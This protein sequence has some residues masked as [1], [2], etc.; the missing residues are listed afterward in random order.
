MKTFGCQVGLFTS[1]LILFFS[2]TA[3]FAAEELPGTAP[4]NATG[5]L[6]AS[7]VDGIHHWLDRATAATPTN[8]AKLWTVAI[9]PKNGAPARDLTWYCHRYDSNRV[10]LR[11]QLGLRDTRLPPALRFVTT[12]N[13]FDPSPT[14][15]E[16]ARGRGYRVFAVEWDVLRDVR[17]EGLLL[18]PD[19]TPRADVIAIPDCE[20][21][22]E[23]IT[24][25]AP[26]LPPEQQFARLLAEHGCRVLVPALIDRS[27]A[28]AGNPDY[29]R[30]QYSQRET[31]WRAAWEMGR[32]PTSYELQKIFA[33]A[34]WL[35]STRPPDRQPPAFDDAAAQSKAGRKG[36]DY[37]ELGVFG[38]GEGG[39]LA[40]LAAA[41]D[42]RFAA[43]YVSGYFGPRERLWEEPIDRDVHG[44]LNEFGDA[45]I[46]ALI[47]PRPLWLES[48][49]YPKAEFTDAHGGAPGRLTSPSSH[50]VTLE[51]ERLQSLVDFPESMLHAEPERF[52]DHTSRFLL[53]LGALNPKVGYLPGPP[54]QGLTPNPNNALRQT[55]LY[56]QLL[57]DTQ[58]LMHESPEIR[59]AFWKK[60]DRSNLARFTNTVGGYRD[61]FRTNTVGEIP[62]PTLPPNPRSRFLGETNGVRR[63]KIQLDLHPDLFAYGIL[64]LPTDLKPGER[65]PVVVCQHGLEGRPTDISDPTIHSQ[66]YHQYGLKLAE[67]GFVTFAPQ[68][69]YLGEAHFR[70]LVRKA[71]PLGLN[72]WSFIVQ[73]HQVITDWLADQPFAD[74]AR[75]GF[76]GLSYGGKTAMRVPALV[77]RYA[78]SIC[79]ADYNEW[80]WKN[81]S[82]TSPYSYLWTVEY[83]MVEWNLANTFNYAELSWLISPRPFMVERGHDDGVA[84]DEWVATEFAKTRR[85]YVKLG[86][87]DQTEI[88]FFDGPHSIHGVGTFDFLHRHLNWRKP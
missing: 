23:Q 45:E 35:E 41:T 61:Y 42:T 4:W 7:M 6:G 27:S 74:P 15:A 60:A 13:G 30:V 33:A 71:H 29:R 44:L 1:W 39:R 37:R 51:H 66:Y 32:T 56:R 52:A 47:A 77:N 79:S 21:T 67:R 14:S 49:K 8:R 38:Y 63:Y 84:P 82:A 11:E 87:G 70:Q 22:P 36:Q 18:L 55:R 72:L 3:L 5:D 48:G 12:S 50:A 86:I 40:Y 28:N 80:V 68:N 57:A 85:H 2:A 69:P 26:G 64:C 17:S 54:P 46:G 10:R 65:R 58:R 43:T 16:I 9:P 25:L 53:A 24:G 88:E 81:V 76:Y 83:D 34:D 19:E 31:L 78:L 20:Q 62:P 73:Q 75:I 59:A